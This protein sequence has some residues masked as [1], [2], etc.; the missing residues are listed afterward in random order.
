MKINSKIIKKWKVLREHGDVA[1][2]VEYTGK[3]QPTIIKALKGE[4]S[5]ETVSMI[6]KFFEERK[7]RVSAL[8]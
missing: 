8:A 3:S 5:E 2:L 4:A 1:A 6:N 7:I